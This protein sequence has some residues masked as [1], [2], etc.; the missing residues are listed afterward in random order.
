MFGRV[1]SSQLS[2]QQKTIS[3][4]CKKNRAQNIHPKQTKILQENLNKNIYKVCLISNS[5]FKLNRRLLNDIFTD[6]SFQCRRGKKA[7]AVPHILGPCMSLA[8][9]GLKTFHIFLS[10]QQSFLRPEAFPPKLST[11]VINSVPL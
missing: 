5:I 4:H 1:S 9:S 3:S 6:F 10:V 2:F 7:T 11:A 8:G